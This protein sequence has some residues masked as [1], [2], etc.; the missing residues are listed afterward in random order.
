[1][2]ATYYITHALAPL[3]HM[4]GAFPKRVSAMPV[5]KP[6]NEFK[7]DGTMVGDRSAIITCLNDD[8]SVFRVTG[9]SQL[10]GHSISYRLCGTKGQIEN[11]RGKENGM[12]LSYNDFNIPEGAEQVKEYTASIR[13]P[14]KCAGCSVKDACRACGAMVITESGCFDKAPRYRCDMMHAYPAQ[15]GRVKEKILWERKNSTF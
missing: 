2:P 12:L 5:Y 8:D 3:M 4:T 1:M 13:L 14:E 7:C 9:W 10:G 15:Y 6:F 11:L